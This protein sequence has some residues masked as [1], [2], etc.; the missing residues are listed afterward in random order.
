MSH[1]TSVTWLKTVA[2]LLIVIGAL[3]SWLTSGPLAAVNLAFLDLAVFPVDGAQTFAATETRLLAAITGGIT[4]GLGMA[5]L[6]ITRHVYEQN[7]VLGRRM[8]LW[9]V[10]TWFVVDGVGSVLAGAA[11]NALLNLVLLAAIILPLL[12]TRTAKAPAHG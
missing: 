3:F 1:G 10:L 12:I 2:W 11:F 7:P 5:I 9:P 4:A 8:I 6:M